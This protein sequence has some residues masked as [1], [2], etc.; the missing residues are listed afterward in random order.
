MTLKQIF[1]N[2]TELPNGFFLAD[3]SFSTA[4][5]G[6]GPGSHRIARIR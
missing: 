4:R 6:K 3:G 5:R 2:T 1:L